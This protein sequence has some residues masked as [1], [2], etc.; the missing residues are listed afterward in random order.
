[1]PTV[2]PPP[3]GALRGALLSN[4]VFSFGTGSALV[5]AP[6]AVAR[7]LGP[8]VPAQPLTVIGSL[9]IGFAFAVGA[10]VCQ[11]RPNRLLALLVSIA[12]LVWGG[13]L[14]AIAVLC[15]GALAEQ[16][17]WLIAFCA[18]A[19]GAFAAAQLRGIARS[20]RA[21]G[22]SG[23]SRVCI[24]IACSASADAL[25]TRIADIGGIARYMP[26]LAHSTLRNGRTAGVGAIRNCADRQGRAWSERCTRWQP[27]RRRFDVEFLCD[28]SCF[29]FPFSR[30]RGGWHVSGRDAGATVRVWWEGRLRRPLLAPL[31]LPLM[32]WQAQRQ[33]VEVVARM[34]T[35]TGEHRR[36]LPSLV[37]VPC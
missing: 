32:E 36:R 28:H 15:S 4:A 7:L 12:D 9:L 30:L 35:T 16:G 3:Y 29:P 27:E 6:G 17:V 2:V 33:F 20:Y 37:A 8:N 22:E 10:L 14:L 1:M 23:E 25:W 19:A 11:Q 31:I 5:L 24:E 18:V 34:A 21:A 26:S 13:G